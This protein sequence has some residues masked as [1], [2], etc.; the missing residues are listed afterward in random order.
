MPDNKGGNILYRVR[1]D[2]I[3]K[4]ALYQE[5]GVREYWIVDPKPRQVILYDLEHKDMPVQ[6]SFSERIKVSVY[7]D[8]YLDLTNLYGTLHD[9][10][11]EER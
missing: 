7:E 1:T 6:F 5:A 11:V 4:L 8:L 2:Y 3:C 10:L 9:V